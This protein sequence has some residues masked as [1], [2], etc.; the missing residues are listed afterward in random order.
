VL[1]AVAR[2]L[3]AEHVGPGSGEVERG[4]LTAGERTLA[5]PLDL[6]VERLRDYKT[7][8]TRSTPD[9]V[10]QA[11]AEALVRSGAR[12]VVAPTDLPSSWLAEIDADAVAVVRDTPGLGAIELERIDATVT[13]SA[14]A[15][16]DTGTVVLDAGAAQGRRII[17]LVPDHLVIVVHAGDVVAGVPDAIARLAPS[18]PQTWISGP[19]AT[20]DIELNRVEGVHGPRRLDVVLVDDLGEGGTERRASEIADD[21]ASR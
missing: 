9:Q 17:S 6:F 13:G 3:A 1:G 4:Y 15:I 5:A 16:A 14:V 19:S 20:S 18:A 7:T 8:V 21:A 10:G 11:V 2:A 12:S